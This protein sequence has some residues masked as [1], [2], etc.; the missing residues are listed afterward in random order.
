M[1]FV[2]CILLT[3]VTL[4]LTLFI[5]FVTVDKVEKTFYTVIFSIGMI[6]MM[7]IGIV[8]IL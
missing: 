8:S 7:T 3:L 4:A 5:N 1:H 6:I 2:L